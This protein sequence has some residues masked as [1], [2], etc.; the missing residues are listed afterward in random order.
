MGRL[1]FRQGAASCTAVPRMGVTHGVQKRNSRPKVKPWAKK[2]AVLQSFSGLKI[3]DTAKPPG[4]LRT[5][6]VQAGVDRAQLTP[7]DRRPG[8]QEQA[9]RGC[10]R[11]FAFPAQ[12]GWRRGHQGGIAIPNFACVSASGDMLSVK[13][14]R[15]LAITRQTPSAPYR[16]PS[17][18]S[19]ARSILPVMSRSFSSW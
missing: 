1:A 16:R 17:E 3:R 18:R 5:R 2:S 12:V 19:S 7:L 4:L 13:C 11:N 9:K 14:L 6:R 8:H 15:Q 10:H